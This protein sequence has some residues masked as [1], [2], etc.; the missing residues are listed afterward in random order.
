MPDMSDHF[1][2]ETTNWAAEN[3]LLWIGLVDDDGNELSGEG[4]ARKP[5]SWT[6]PAEDADNTIYPT[7][8]IV[9]DV[10]SGYVAGWRAY[11]EESTGQGNDMGGKDFTTAYYYTDPGTFALRSDE[12]GVRPV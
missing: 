12:T 10:P 9:F 2:Q 4:Y 1:K 6:D 7:G 5:A 11:D 8:D 3:L